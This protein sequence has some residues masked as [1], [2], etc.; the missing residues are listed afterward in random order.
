MLPFSS[1]QANVIALIVTAAVGIGCQDRPKNSGAPPASQKLS[2]LNHVH[3]LYPIAV[4]KS[5]GQPL[6]DE[7]QR[8][9]KAL[10]IEINVLVAEHNP[11][12]C[13][14]IELDGW[15]PNPGTG[16]YI[17]NVQPGGARITGS[18]LEQIRLAIDRLKDMLIEEKGAKQVPIGLF[19]NYPLK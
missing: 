7:G 6:L 15:R 19:T 13:F 8:L 11:T 2:Q 14:W 9:R 1:K 3:W 10:G 18:D 17:I 12:C 16:G 4:A 5:G